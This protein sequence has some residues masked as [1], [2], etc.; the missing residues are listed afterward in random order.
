M[1]EQ[2]KRWEQEVYTNWVK[3]NWKAK[4]PVFSCGPQTR[5][6]GELKIAV[7]LKEDK[8]W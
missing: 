2:S 6:P 4:S 7:K 8:L 5:S 1:E 3:G